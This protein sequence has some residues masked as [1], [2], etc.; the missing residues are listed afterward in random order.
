MFQSYYNMKCVYTRP[1]E[2]I[3]LNI[4]KSVG[5]RSVEASSLFSVINKI[6]IIDPVAQS[7]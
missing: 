1:E 5:N 3:Y 6:Y 2:F 4:A 7:I